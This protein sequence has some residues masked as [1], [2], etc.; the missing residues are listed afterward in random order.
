MLAVRGGGE[1]VALWAQLATIME[2]ITGVVGA[3]VGTGLAVY[4]ARTRREARQLDLLREALRLGLLSTLPV[5]LAIAVLG[6]LFA[7]VLSGGKVPAAW[8]AAGAASGW[9]SVAVSLLNSLWLGQQRR[10]LILAFT[11][12]AALPS[13]AVVFLAPF[14]WVLPLLVAV[15]A[16]P[17]AL[18]FFVLK[19]P[20]RAPRFRFGSHPLRRYILPG[21]SIGIL[22]AASTFGARSVV[23]E[24]L[25]WHEAGILQGLWRIADAI[26]AFAGGILSVIYLPRFAAARGTPEFPREVRNAALWIVLPSALVLAAAY[27]AHR[28]LLAL[29]YDPQFVAPEA[30]VAWIFGGSLL[31]IGSWIPLFALYAM[32]RTRSIAVGELF[33]LPLFAVL[34]F[35]DADRLSLE[36]IGVFWLLSYAAYLTFNAWAARRG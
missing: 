8:F 12:G 25:S 20:A 26:G 36:R 17:A 14:A 32:R 2:L 13:F 10:D 33:S 19:G 22:S 16:L 18:L 3:G 9:V 27:L 23:G 35:L 28:P 24:S 5:A 30:A 7:E 15:Q 21:F 31:R 4:V 6:A 29:L 1:M 34:V 11:I